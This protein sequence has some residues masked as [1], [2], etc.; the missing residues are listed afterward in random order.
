MKKFTIFVTLFSF[1]TLESK[2]FEQ[3]FIAKESG[4]IVKQIGNCSKEHSPYS[5]FK[6]AIAVMGFD[7]GILKS[8]QSPT[9]QA[10]KELDP[11]FYNLKKY[12]IQAFAARAQTPASWMQYSV[13]WYSQEITKKLGDQKFAEYV[14]KLNYGNKDVSG[15]LLQAWL[16]S[17]L[18]I[19]PLQQVEFVEKLSERK[20]PVAKLAQNGAVEIMKMEDIYNSWKMY[21]KTGSSSVDGWFVG[22]IEKNNRRII[23]AQYLE[24]KDAAISAGRL[25][26]EVAKDNLIE[27]VL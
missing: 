16:G 6:I 19:T 14:E 5:T 15:G 9:I 10:P 24:A 20:L 3:C 8:P 2:A 11:K 18:K 12:P 1:V 23:F 17:S 26:K 27:L 13:I 7:S 25:A 22:Y 21:G 4:K